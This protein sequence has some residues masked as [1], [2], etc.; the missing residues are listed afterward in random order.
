MS[1]LLV[2]RDND[3]WTAVI[4][5]DGG[6]G[7]Q[8]IPIVLD[9]V[10]HQPKSETPKTRQA[11]AQ[12]EAI[13]ANAKKLR[14]LENDCDLVRRGDKHLCFSCEARECPAIQQSLFDLDSPAP[15]C[16]PLPDQPHT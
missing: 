4:V 12:Q 9:E 14:Q 8:T 1:V 3:H 15:R 5:C 7:Y 11:A 6:C 10:R 2:A 13:R 16:S